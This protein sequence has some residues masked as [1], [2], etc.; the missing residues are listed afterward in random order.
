MNRRKLA[1]TIVVCL[2]AFGGIASAAYV[3]S[4]IAQYKDGVPCGKLTGVPGLLQKAHFFSAEAH[5][6]VYDNDK[7]RCKDSNHCEVFVLSKGVLVDS[8][9]DGN[10][11]TVAK[12]CVCVA[13]G[14]DT[15]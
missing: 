10:C 2:I 9:K 8:G 13:Q 12:T 6:C 3:H 15:E 14:N 5:D 1:L 7:G 11:R 4:T